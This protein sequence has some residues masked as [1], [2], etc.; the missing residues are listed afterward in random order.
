MPEDIPPCIHASMTDTLKRHQGLLRDPGT[1]CSLG[2]PPRERRS[3]CPPHYRPSLQIHRTMYG[4]P[5]CAPSPAEMTGAHPAKC[6]PNAGD[7]TALG[8]QTSP[9][10]RC[11]ASTLRRG[12]SHSRRV[13][14]LLAC[15]VSSS[16]SM[17]AAMIL[18][19]WACASLL[20]TAG[21]VSPTSCRNTSSPTVDLQFVR[22][23]LNVSAKM[24][25]YPGEI[26]TRRRTCPTAKL[27][28]LA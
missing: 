1:T 2:F 8:S 21:A 15:G 18:E 7:P 28:T 10:D 24:F 13:A 27:T 9:I 23:L 14:R 11:D 17:I 6:H 3:H 12:R 22:L 25:L 4:A 26:K 16:G 20:V 5:V 19:A